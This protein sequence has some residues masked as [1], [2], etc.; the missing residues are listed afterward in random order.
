MELSAHVCKSSAACTHEKDH[1]KK[2]F[3]STKVNYNFRGV[4]G[5]I[6]SRQRDGQMKGKINRQSDSVT[7]SVAHR[8]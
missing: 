1:V 4:N 8:R 3:K 5:Q 6:R 7:S 2:I